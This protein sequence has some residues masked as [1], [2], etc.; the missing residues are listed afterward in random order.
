MARAATTAVSL[1]TDPAGPPGLKRSIAELLPH[2]WPKDAPEL[3]VRVVLAFIFL[4]LAK[5]VN[6]AIPFFY[7]AI[8][9]GLS[10]AEGGLIVLPLAAL[11]AY[12]GARFGATAVRSAARWDLRQGRRARRPQGLAL[13]LPAPVPAVACATTSSGA[14]ASWRAPSIAASKP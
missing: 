9:D 8:V 1:M 14:P 5:L 13:G 6:V 11:I 4:L 12:G 7:K 3:R 2:L 10:P